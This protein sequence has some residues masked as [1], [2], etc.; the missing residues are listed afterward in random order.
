MPTIELEMLA[1][2]HLQQQVIDNAAR[3]NVLECGRRFGKTELGK[4]LTCDMALQ[5]KRAAWF[6]PTYK[7]MAEQWKEL[8]NTLRPVLVTSNKVEQ[9]MTLIGGGVIDFWTLDNPDS[10]RG[11][12]YH[13]VIIDEASIVR[14]IEQAWQETI[15]PTLTDFKGDA[16]FLG[17]PKGRRFFHSLYQKGQQGDRGWKS[18]R[19]ATVENPFMSSS[20]VADAKADL[21]THVFEQEYL[22]IPADDGGNP[23]GIDAIRACIKPL[24]TNTPVAFGVDLAKSYD[25]TVIIG[26]DADG[27]VCRYERFQ[28]DWG[29]TTDRIL[30]TV[31]GWPTLVDSTGVGDPIV[32]KMQR[33]RQNIKG[34][35]FS[36]RSKQQIMEG[37]A[38]AI[39]RQGVSFPQGEIVDELECFE[40]EYTKTGVRYEAPHGLHDDCVCSLA[41][42]LQQLS[43]PRA[44][45]GY[46]ECD[47]DDDDYNEDSQ[48][49]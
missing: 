6:A 18:W 10:G 39:H 13:R 2:H 33:V 48:W 15:R 16:W 5:G 11:R 47:D 23:F 24:S 21:P 17:T 41:L 36:S 3:F 43:A 42:A 7:T 26:V 12:K 27:Q 32:E 9:Q 35:N 19:F 30:A 29:N 25:W 34:F 38:S 8:A 46:L 37:L 49:Q 40:Y 22:G 45:V 20:E 28:M 31:N 1:P 14:H 4:K 44:Y